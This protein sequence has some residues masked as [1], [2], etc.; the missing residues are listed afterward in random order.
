MRIESGK[1]LRVILLL[2]KM[3]FSPS[4]LNGDGVI[5]ANQKRCIAFVLQNNPIAGDPVG[6]IRSVRDLGF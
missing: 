4:I 2:E 6:V 3:E 5:F 1:F